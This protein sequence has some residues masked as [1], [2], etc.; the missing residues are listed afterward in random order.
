[1]SSFI[2]LF[3]EI[4]LHSQPGQPR[5]GRIKDVDQ[6][7]H[8]VSLQTLSSTVEAPPQVDVFPRSDIASITLIN[9]GLGPPAADP[10]PNQ[11]RPHQPQPP[12]PTNPPPPPPS[13]P[14]LASKLS[15][16]NRKLQSTPP[17]LPFPSSSPSPLPTFSDPAIV[18]FDKPQT[19]SAKRSPQPP[20]RQTVQSHPQTHALPVPPPQPQQPQALTQ[21][22]AASSQASSS[23][24]KPPSSPSSAHL[25][26][27]VLAKSANANGGMNP[28][29]KT[30]NHPLSKAQQQQHH[31]QHHHQN[32]T[33]ANSARSATPRIN[34][35]KQTPA[36]SLGFE[37]EFDFGAG[38]RQ[39]DKK[40]IWEEI[41]SSDQTDPSTLLVSHNRISGSAQPLN[42]GPNSVGPANSTT[43]SWPA[44]AGGA[45]GA[46][47]GQTKLG[48]KEMVLSPSPPTK[49]RLEHDSDLE[50]ISDLDQSPSKAN[51]SSSRSNSKPK[52]PSVTQLGLETKG[53][54]KEDLGG[55]RK[56]ME[57]KGQQHAPNHIAPSRMVGS[58]VASVDG[59]PS[60]QE[61]EDEIRRLRD[62]LALARRRNQLLEELAGL[63]LGGS[64]GGSR[65]GSTLASPSLS[66]VE[67]LFRTGGG[68]ESDEGDR[69]KGSKFYKVD[70]ESSQRA[71]GATE[72]E[73]SDRQAAGG[74]KQSRRIETA[75][76]KGSKGGGIEED[77]QE[78]DE[79]Q[80]EDEGKRFAK[81]LEPPL[82]TLLFASS[83]SQ[84]AALA[85]VEAFYESSSNSKQYMDLKR[86]KEEKI[87]NNYQGF[88]LP[89]SA[90]R[91]WFSKLR[92][93]VQSAK[94]R[95]AGKEGE[96]GEEKKDVGDDDDDGWKAECNEEEVEFLE[97]LFDLGALGREE[98]EVGSD[99]DKWKYIISTVAAQCLST[100]PH[101]RLHA[102]YHL[103]ERYRD[104]V[105]EQWSNLTK[106]TR[107]AI[108]Q[109]L[110]MRKY[111]ESVFQ[112]EFQAY[113]AEGPR[114]EAEFGNKCKQEC[115][116]VAE[117]LRSNVGQLWQ[118]VIQQGSAGREGEEQQA[119][120]SDS[121]RERLWERTKWQVLES[122]KR[123]K[124]GGGGLAASGGDKKGAKG[125]K[126]GKAGGKKVSSK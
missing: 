44:G 3:V 62:E 38:L 91:E 99:D 95:G 124:R 25:P 40:K 22:F 34:E 46:R 35:P 55:S 58:A 101:E 120:M 121:E 97:M 82:I 70:D 64:G 106:V 74:A 48:P 14:T 51:R 115:K 114:T 119:W 63:G 28:K 116:Q 16:S 85:R 113:L 68:K 42:R 87:C 43:S 79:Q 24:S 69:G 90:V 96:E 7:K 80:E 109:D 78:E 88:N 8:T 26:S 56:R 19:H 47:N 86:A 94:G 66:N 13:L 23:S 107:K 6:S 71:S 5:L 108:E 52:Q 73:E 122:D 118:E 15:N 9:N 117:V 123:R 112:D 29:K 72:A 53:G 49:A 105:S 102:L 67:S 76:R 60:Y 39:F 11:S 36:A 65:A 17:P 111:S 18:S 83:A 33:S 27:P 12:N 89:I 77:V 31:H 110:G 59:K 10:K 50:S 75:D 93:H 100:L 81:L 125:R 41:R 54:K 4:K 32:D 45:A 104:L 98:G 30:S 84:H 126:K 61:L 20:H 92:S 103:S 57:G 1:M 37:E 21:L 2:G